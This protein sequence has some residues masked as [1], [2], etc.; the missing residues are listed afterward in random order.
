MVKNFNMLIKGVGGQGIVTLV[1]IIAE[2]AF[3]NGYDVKSSELH[4]L[5]QRE[6]SVQA[7]IKFGKKVYS[8][9]VYK[10]QADLVIGQELL[11]GL[12][13][14]ELA[15]SQTKFLINMFNSPFI[16]SMKEQEILDELNKLPKDKLN[17]VKAS[18]ICK[19]KLGNQVLSSVY[20]LGYAISRKLMPLKKE[21]VLQAIKNVIPEK[22]REMNI[23]ALELGYGQ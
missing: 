21:S 3:L 4:G 13:S 15:G 23:K 20:L 16:G 18:E 1:A 14:V 7:H 2:S 10:G 19:D 9:L 17:L 22:Y 5:S 8:P 11:E 6:G 12:R